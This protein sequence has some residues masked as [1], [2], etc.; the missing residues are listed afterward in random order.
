MADWMARWLTEWLT[1]WLTEWVDDSQ[2][3][4]L[5]EGVD[6]WM[7][8][9]MADWLK[10]LLTISLAGCVRLVGLPEHT[11]PSH[12]FSVYCPLDPKYITV[13]NVLKDKKKCQTQRPNSIHQAS[14]PRCL[15]GLRSGK[16]YLWSNHA[17]TSHTAQLLI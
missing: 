3:G 12:Q 10:S 1:D 11:L 17:A 7:T 13:K 5:T 15:L 2:S 16:D 8:H 14:P 6:D 9:I 4:W